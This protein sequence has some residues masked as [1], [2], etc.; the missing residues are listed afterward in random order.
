ML[1]TLLLHYPEMPAEQLTAE[2]MQQGQEAFGI[3]GA[4]ADAA[5]VLVSANMLQPAASATTVSLLDGALSVKK[6]AY[7][8]TVEQLGGVVVVDVPDLISA[9]SWAEQAP[10]VQWGTVEIRAGA[11]HWADG[12]WASSTDTSGG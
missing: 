9:I 2:A 8:T 6:G 10:S 1:Y 7:A 3:F 4:A 5:G 12:D 11:V